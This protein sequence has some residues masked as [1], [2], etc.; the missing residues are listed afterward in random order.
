MVQETV[1]LQ[2]QRPELLSRQPAR[3]PKN[4]LAQADRLAGERSE[5]ET[6][7]YSAVRALTGLYTRPWRRTVG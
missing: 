5:D 1:P 3:V 2:H 6:P 7:A 4:Y